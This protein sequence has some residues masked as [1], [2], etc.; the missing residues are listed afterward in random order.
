[1]PGFIHPSASFPPSFSGLCV[2]L[3]SEVGG[4]HQL[5]DSFSGCLSEDLDMRT[6]GV[7]VLLVCLC[8]VSPGQGTNA[9]V[10]SLSEKSEYETAAVH[11]PAI[12]SPS[13]NTGSS[14]PLSLGKKS[15]FL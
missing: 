5:S 3:P 11:P 13:V 4:E 1:M 2:I 8:I 14:S 9:Y 6:T 15:L 7:C 12:T 10:E